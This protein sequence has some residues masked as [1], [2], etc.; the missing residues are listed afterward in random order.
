MINYFS[1]WTYSAIYSFFVH[2]HC[3]PHP[4]TSPPTRGKWMKLMK[5][6]RRCASWE[7]KWIWKHRLQRMLKMS[8][9]QL[10]LISSRSQRQQSYWNR[11]GF[12]SSLQ[13]RTV[14]T[15]LLFSSQC[16][17]QHERRRTQPTTATCSAKSANLFMSHLSFQHHSSFLQVF[18]INYRPKWWKIRFS[19]EAD[20]ISRTWF[21]VGL[22][23]ICSK[24]LNA[25]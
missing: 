1:F 25:T 3:P 17:L 6:P 8:K 13:I 10:S 2:S 16:I 21:W 9:L 7:C 20:I 15:G 18:S 22:P 23:N 5:L 14:L 24:F 11:K 4:L 12:R 19:P